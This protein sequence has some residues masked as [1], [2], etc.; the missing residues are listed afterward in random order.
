MSSS[1][2]IVL[3]LVAGLLT[4]FA[5]AATGS[6]SFDAAVDAD[7]P[8]RAASDGAILPPPDSSS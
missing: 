7:N 3:G 8:F 1:V 2:H 4:G 5:L 6:T